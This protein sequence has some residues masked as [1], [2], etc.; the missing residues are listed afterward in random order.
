[1]KVDG[2]YV[3]Y[4]C[5]CKYKILDHGPPMRI[6]WDIDYDNLNY[7]CEATWDFIGQGNTKGIFQLET[8]FGQQM[9]KKLKPN[10]LEQLSALASILRPGPLE[11]RIDGKSLTEHYIDR[12]NGLDEVKYFHPSLEPILKDTYGVL[13][14]QEESMAIAAQLAGF[15]MAESNDLRKG[16]GKKSSVIIAALKQQFIEGCEKIG[17]VNKE[18]AEEIFGWIEKGQR[19][20]FNASHG[21]SYAVNGYMSAY[22]KCHTAK[23]F[24]TS[25]LFYA[26]EKPKKF[27][28][29][30]LLV[31]DAKSM[32]IEIRPPSLS[33]LHEHFKRIE[34]KIVFGLMDIKEFGES[35][36]KQAI[37]TIEE[38][39]KNL[40]K[41][42]DQFTWPEFLILVAQNIKTP[43][44]RGMI[45]CG[46]LD[47]FKVDR[48]RM[49]FEFEQCCI[50]SPKELKFVRENI[51]GTFAE[52]L[53]FALQQEKFCMKN[54][55]GKLE[56]IMGSL[57]RPPYSLADTPDWIAKVEEARMGVSLT[58]SVVD[59]CKDA[60]QA[61]A[62]CM[63]V[64]SGKCRHSGIFLAAQLKEVKSTTTKNGKNPGQEMAFVT[65]SDHSGELDAVIFPDAWK[66]IFSSNV[67]F[68]G[69]LVL[70]S[71]EVDKKK[72]SFV[73]KNMWQLS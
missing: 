8:R 59:G 43:A 40:G 41:P 60:D 6:E 35:A 17:K 18:E 33:C 27:D 34:G 50:L 68:D 4:E 14:Y 53:E 54:R 16:L 39:T 47:A 38:E 22:A 67:C 46:V 37:K 7:E 44:V 56:N 13:I 49:L 62:C 64:K 30:K 71:G 24:S 20:L 55:R 29:I 61:N 1:M 26:K 5:G 19:Y 57:K 9:A 42:I 66:D 36:Y 11:S 3:V 12:K 28:E 2:D 23:S 65:F 15:T 32:N 48:L 25:Y 52:T 73:V 58:C 10:N 51:R 69:N 70:I 72:G 21:F 45:E 63:D 31:N